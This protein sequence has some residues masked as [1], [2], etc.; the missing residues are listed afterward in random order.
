LF[1]QEALFRAPFVSPTERSGG[2]GEAWSEGEVTLIVADYLEMLRAEVEGRRYV[3]ADHWR[4]LGPQLNSRTKGAIEQKHMN[5]SAI[6][7][8]LGYPFIAGYKPLRNYQRLLREKVEE[9][10]ARASWLPRTDAGRTTHGRH[11]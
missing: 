2:R 4:A 5:I 10:A 6:L 8:E 9:Q 3:K 11:R 7:Q 1:A